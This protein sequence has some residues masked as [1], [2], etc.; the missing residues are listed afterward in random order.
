MFIYFTGGTQERC[1]AGGSYGIAVNVA[2][3]IDFIKET[4]MDG[5]FCVEN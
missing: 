4:A 1:S 5:E 2:S 3:F